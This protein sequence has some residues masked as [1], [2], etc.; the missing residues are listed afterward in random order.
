MSR[1]GD[2]AGRRGRLFRKYVVVLVVLVG[3]VLLVS[4]GLQAYFSYQETKRS[5][6]RIQR[7]QAAV[8][9]VRIEQFMLG[10]LPPIEA[11]DQALRNI[12][13]ATPEQRQSEYRRVLRQL[14][15][16]TEVRH[17]DAAG[18]EQVRI[19]RLETDALGSGI[20]RSAEPLV[21]QALHGRP[22][23]SSVY[24]RHE[25]EPYLTL[26]LTEPGADAGVT[27]ADVNLKF[28]WDVVSQMTVGRNGIAYV[29]DAEGRLIA[30]PDISLVLRQ[31]DLTGLSQVR[32]AQAEPVTSNQQRDTAVVARNQQGGQVLTAY[33][34]VEPPGWSVFVEQP[35]GE[36]FAPLYAG[37]LRT[38]VLLLAGLFLAV[39]ASIVLARRMVTP[40]RSLQGG[41]AR[42]G[43][44][45][46]A[47]RI[48]IRTG[49]ELESL[50][51]EFNQMSAQ[52][53]DSHAG[54][55]RKV[56]ERTRELDAANRAKSEFLSRMSHELRT[57]LNAILGFAE[58]MEMSS[59]TPPRQREWV[60]HQLKAGR[61]LLAL[62]DE[63]LDIARIEAGR[64]SLTPGVVRV[65]EVIAET[66]DLVQ[67]LA[68]QRGVAVE[69]DSAS[70]TRFAVRA[71]HQRLKQV[72]LNLLTNAVKYN[73]DGGSVWVSCYERPSDRLRLVV[74]DTGPGIAEESL[75]RLFTPFERLGADGS[76]VEGTGLGLAIAQRLI[77]AMDGAIGV[78]STLGAGSTIWVELPRA[79]E[80]SAQQVSATHIEPRSEDDRCEVSGMVLYIEDNLPNLT[81]MEQ[82]LGL[83]PKVTLLSAFEG[84]RGL[85]I[86]GDSH[87]D[88]ILL[89]LNLPDLSGEEIL[90]RL[91]ADT[92][93]HDIPVVMISADASLAQQERLVRAGAHSYLT[94]PL[95]VRQLLSLVD[96]ILQHEAV[97]P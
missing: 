8:A 21:R 1:S 27:L 14:P 19:S 92:R 65:N 70:L 26:A 20:D 15:P 24:F 62:I 2:A 52:L 96:A 34:T 42:I 25:S 77:E 75:L 35:L 47:Q 82:A 29:V 11:A 59:Q 56:A 54:L 12:G 28:I 94:K 22:A 7:E 68:A 64:L 40:I 89:D 84:R 80:Q 73:R 23:F 69:V 32:T 58:I 36:A 16:I 86:A 74:R 18:R 50:A 53:R 9:T 30:H 31:T 38:G 79:V 63:V 72:L 49:D 43:S 33:T 93:T 67:P 37:L 3:S 57:P 90:H 51:D 55:E 45:D 41:A 10:V 71:D 66:V 97:T 4:G 39:L 76:G 87:P 6:G 17:I 85:E 81:L 48:D 91:R 46:L 83:R 78:E 5:L 88:L 60:Q 61:H 95:E 44:G 13:A